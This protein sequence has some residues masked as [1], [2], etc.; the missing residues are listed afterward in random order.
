MPQIVVA[1]TRSVAAAIRM[2]IGQLSVSPKTI[3]KI[4]QCFQR[5][6]LANRSPDWAAARLDIEIARCSIAGMPDEWKAKESLS[7]VLNVL[8]EKIN[9]GIRREGEMRALLASGELSVTRGGR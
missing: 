5:I 4:E 8:G 7:N 1:Q 9:S 3:D 6:H 2:K